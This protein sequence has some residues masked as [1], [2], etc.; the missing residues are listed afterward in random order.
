[1]AALSR[2]RAPTAVRQRIVQSLAL[3]FL[4]NRPTRQSYSTTAVWRKSE[5]KKGESSS[6]SSSS[7]TLPPVKQSPKV[8]IASFAKDLHRELLEAERILPVLPWNDQQ[9]EEFANIDPQ[10]IVVYDK[11]QHL[12][13]YFL[14][15]V[16]EGSLQ[17]DGKHRRESSIF[18][19]SLLRLFALAHH[20]EGGEKVWKACATIL[21]FIKDN[22]MNLLT[23]HCQSALAV[24][25]RYGYISQAAEL[26][27]RQID[28]A[29]L[30]VATPYT[31]MS[32][33]KPTG[34]Y[35]VAREAQHRGGLPV[36]N[37]MQAVRQLCQSSAYDQDMFVLAAGTALGH[38]NEGLGLI[39]YINTSLEAPKLGHALVA[40]AMQACILSNEAGAAWNLWEERNLPP[41]CT[42]LALRAS[43]AVADKIDTEYVLELY[44]TL[45]D[46]GRAVSVEAMVGLMQV[47]ERHGAWQQAVEIWLRV[48]AGAAAG[49]LGLVYGDELQSL[50]VMMDADKIKQGEVIK[51]LSH[52]VVPVLRACQAAEQ[53]A[54][55]LMCLSLWQGC[56]EDPK[57]LMAAQADPRSWLTR[58]KFAVLESTNADDFLVAVMASLSGFEL[59]NEACELYDMCMESDSTENWIQ[60]TDLREFSSAKSS[61][62]PRLQRDRR[63]ATLGNEVQRFVLA[64]AQSDNISKEDATLISSALATIMESLSAWR[65]PL[66]GQYL[67][68]FMMDK[69]QSPIVLDDVMDI[70]SEYSYKLPIT[71]SLGAALVM[72]YAKQDEGEKAL[73]TFDAV[74]RGTSSNQLGADWPLTSNVAIKV[75]FFNQAVDEAMNLF[76]YVAAENRNP[77]LYAA[78]AR[79]LASN[80]CWKEVSDVYRLALASRALSEEIS[81]T[82]MNAIEH[83]QPYQKIRLM[84]SIAEEAA[85]ATGMQPLEWVERNYHGLKKSITFSSLRKLL[86]WDHP[87]TAFLDE[88]E[89]VLGQWEARKKA[90]SNADPPTAPLLASARIILNTA[91]RFE[92][93]NIPDNKTKI[94]HVPRSPR[95][96]KRLV[97]EIVEELDLTIWQ[98]KSGP[99]LAADV[100]ESYFHLGSYQDCLSFAFQ[101]LEN[102]IPLKPDAL[103]PAIKAAKALDDENSLRTL[104][105][106]SK[107]EEQ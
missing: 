90:I 66:A 102:E 34:L 33:A 22:R 60:A 104:T 6:S 10:R 81:M 7:S 58:L 43:P 69:D 100:I 85:A 37:V 30:G 99:G 62:Y 31:N 75:L 26:F 63:L 107:G 17:P 89:L 70:V 93:E 76:Q 5:A 57:S 74:T 4:H 20:P 86:W 67:F 71:D 53:Y 52:V 35:A 15:L 50:D 103:K 47:L 84:R 32:I 27:L 64:K 49:R 92:R 94:P 56:C 96:W 101:C 14:T 78:V 44:E 41:L 73:Q 88:L 3:H 29:V 68:R 48:M 82:A 19:E 40:A 87:E 105:M 97:D 98:S 28:P 54:L 106:I 24:A 9:T 83:L 38:A 36:E 2:C 61:H 65:H 42:D 12:L 55:G 8:L 45:V 77:S 25:V 1:M 91:K 95:A 23:T 21:D 13:D 39:N 46:A 59:P 80:E 18:L 16:R 51:E 79:G 72:S 11:A